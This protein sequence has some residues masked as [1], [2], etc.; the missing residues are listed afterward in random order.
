MQCVSK[1]TINKK[2]ASVCLFQQIITAF[3]GVRRPWDNT[4]GLLQAIRTILQAKP[5]GLTPQQIRD[6]IKREYPSLYGTDSHRS[7][8]EK[9]HYKDL[10]HALLAQIYV[11]YRTASDIYAD[12]SVKPM[13]FSLMSAEM[14][15][16]SS[17]EELVEFENLEKLEEGR[18]TLYVLGTNL[19]TKSGDE[20][21]KIGITTGYVEQRINQLY[22]TS[23]PYRFRVIKQTETKNYAEL[24]QSLHRILDPFRIN[25]SREYF[26]EKCL[27]YIDSLVSIHEDIQRKA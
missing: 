7:N 2:I 16:A 18:G 20:I 10:D 19:F 15:P 11:A 23:V 13:K 1:V 14:V 17:E 12:K 8:V 6:V 5:D 27:P 4:V 22:T 9:G 26:T 24:E 25:R 21:V 3:A